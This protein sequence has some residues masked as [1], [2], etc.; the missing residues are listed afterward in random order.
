MAWDAKVVVKMSLKVAMKL[1]K[2]AV[3]GILPV[4]KDCQG[5]LD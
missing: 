4:S 5:I 3:A 2:L 1:L